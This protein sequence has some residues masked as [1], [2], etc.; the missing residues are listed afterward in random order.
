MNLK[1]LRKLAEAAHP[2]PWQVLPYGAGNDIIRFS[3]KDENR[4]KIC[5][6]IGKPTAEYIAE[7]NPVN[8]IYLLDRIDELERL[9]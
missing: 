2:G 6:G 8:I 3:I 1:K 7:V 9:K 5:S 4:L